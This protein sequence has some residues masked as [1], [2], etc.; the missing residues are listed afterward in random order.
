MRMARIVLCHAS[1]ERDGMQCSLPT[2]ISP[3]ILKQQGLL[4][5]VPTPDP[6]EEPADSFCLV[7]SCL[8]LGLL[9]LS[10]PLTLHDVVPRPLRKAQAGGHGL[11][12]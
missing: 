8:G 1:P 7:P 9:G 6:S 4:H 11:D 12:V 3:Q 2:I 5:K 10:Q